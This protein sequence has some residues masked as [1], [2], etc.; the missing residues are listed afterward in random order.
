MI[1]FGETAVADSCRQDGLYGIVASLVIPLRT[2]RHHDPIPV[3]R[4]FGR[5]KSASVRFRAV[6]EPI[7]VQL[8]HADVAAPSFQ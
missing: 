6:T 7:C 4:N 2:G 8:C 5:P 3:E 1:E